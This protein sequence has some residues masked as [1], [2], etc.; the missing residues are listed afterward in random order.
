ME[1]YYGAPPTPLT[2]TCEP[3]Y[4]LLRKP[5]EIRNFLKVNYSI[6]TVASTIVV[7]FVSWI[8]PISR[9]PHTLCGHP[10]VLF[11]QR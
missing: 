9:N 10:D 2:G 3:S 6:N 7:A 11:K 8:K 1:E 4:R 5:V